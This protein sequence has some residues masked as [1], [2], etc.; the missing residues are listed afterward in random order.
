MNVGPLESIIIGHDNS[1]PGAG[2]YLDH[3]MYQYSATFQYYN[4]HV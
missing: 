1:G 4:I 2:W 3:V